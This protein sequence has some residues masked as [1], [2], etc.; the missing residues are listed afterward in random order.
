MQESVCT[1]SQ[2]PRWMQVFLALPGIA[3]LLCV[4]VNA[5]Y[6][7][8]ASV[9]TADAA[10]T[11]AHQLATQGRFASGAMAAEVACAALQPLP[12][13]GLDCSTAMVR[14]IA[15]PRGVDDRRIAQ[16]VVTYFAAPLVP[17]P[18]WVH[19]MTVSRTAWVR[20]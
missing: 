8:Y 2:S 10:A 20:S 11:A 5:S 16:V 19:K 17:V 9:L 3:M 6:Y 15:G 14:V 4:L 7:R 18:G 1:I 12:D 13:V